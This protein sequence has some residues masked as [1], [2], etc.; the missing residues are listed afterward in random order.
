VSIIGGGATTALL[1]IGKSDAIA[2]VETANATAKSAT[3][4]MD[5]R[6]PRLIMSSPITTY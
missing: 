1:R 3:A 2:L 5:I 6:D 4:L